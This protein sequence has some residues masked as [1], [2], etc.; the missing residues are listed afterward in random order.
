MDVPV[1][2]LIHSYLKFIFNIFYSITIHVWDNKKMYLLV[3]AGITVSYV[4]INAGLEMSDTEDTVDTEKE[5]LHEQEIEDGEPLKQYKINPKLKGLKNP[6]GIFSAMASHNFNTL[7]GPHV[8]A[9]DGLH[10][11]TGELTKQ[12]Q[13]SRKMV[14][15]LRNSDKKAYLDAQNKI[16]N[17]YTRLVWLFKK[18]IKIFSDM[19]RFMEHIFLALLDTLF[20]LGSTWNGVIGATVRFFCFDEFTKLD[21][22]V[23]IKDIKIGDKIG[24]NCFVKSVMKFASEYNEMFE[25][26]GIIISGSHEVFENGKWVRVSQ[27]KISNMIIYNKPFIYCLETTTGEIPI[28]GIRFKDFYETIDKQLLNNYY[29]LF[30][31][32][33]NTGNINIKNIQTQKTS[34]YNTGFTNDT[35]IKC[36]GKETTVDKVKIGDTIFGSRVIGL[37]KT[38][39]NNIDLYE[40]KNIKC[41]GNNVIYNNGSYKLIKNIG[42][43]IKNETNYLYHIMTDDNR[44]I[45]DKNEF[46]D[47]NIILDDKIIDMTDHY[48]STHSNL[49]ESII[50]STTMP[51]VASR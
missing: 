30:K 36:W 14:Y 41:S 26:N 33:L 50:F 31:D 13:Q 7:I 43:K 9:L 49:K 15:Y 44:L 34:Y 10:N 45:L 6:G 16:L 11:I 12:M 25:Y 20:I 40:Y 3:L 24:N 32:Y 2:N 17:I 1:P 23:F 21:N 37:A 19:F 38:S 42:K 35:K 39:S 27:S 4:L 5:I 8:K 48:M 28:K 22:G 18:I 47:F 46:R 29:T 51:C